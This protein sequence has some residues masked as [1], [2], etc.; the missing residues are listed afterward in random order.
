MTQFRLKWLSIFFLALGSGTG[1]WAHD[2]GAALPH[3]HPHPAHVGMP[4]MLL[5][6]AL[7]GGSTL[8]GTAILMR[9]RQR[10]GIERVR[11]RFDR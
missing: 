8:L 1:A 3:P 9:R 10:N 5:G 6:F 4:E 11:I 2:L 7:I